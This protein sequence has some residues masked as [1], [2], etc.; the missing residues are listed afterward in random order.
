MTASGGSGAVSAPYAAAGYA[1]DSASF[2]DQVASASVA[3]ANTTY[4]VRYVANISS[5]TEAG[6]YNSTLTYVGTANF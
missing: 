6:T 1:L 4:S 2:P 5:L 3:S